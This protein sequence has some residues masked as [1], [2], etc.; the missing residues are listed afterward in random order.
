MSTPFQ[1]LSF[2]LST[3]VNVLT[4][5]GI[6][7]LGSGPVSNPAGLSPTEIMP[8]TSNFTNVSIYL[9]EKMLER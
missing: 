7:L 6:A 5:I 1:L 3:L 2:P 9:S 4:F 8:K